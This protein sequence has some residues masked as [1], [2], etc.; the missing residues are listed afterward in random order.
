M[1]AQNISSSDCNSCMDTGCGT[2]LINRE[3]L[4]NQ[5]P[6]AKILKMATPLKVRG[7]GTS[8]HKT[9]KYILK[10]LYFPAISNKGQ[11]VV[12]CIHCE[13]YFVNNLR[14]NILIGND[15]IG[16]KGIT[17]DIAKEKA[18]IPGCQATISITAR[19][20]GQFIRKVLHSTNH[21]IIPPQL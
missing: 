20:H 11:Q 3:W 16:A 14:A 8:K 5:L 12:A 7:M 9:N 19:Q 15:I 13:L 10:T 21:V 4:K 6:K 2:M 1:N 17:I 18:Y